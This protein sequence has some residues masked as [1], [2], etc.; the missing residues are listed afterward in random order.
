[1]SIYT[2]VVALLLICCAGL[3]CP[4]L[5]QAGDDGEPRQT[6][7]MTHMRPESHSVSCWLIQV[8]EEAFDR[9]G[10]GMRYRYIPAARA[11]QMA[12]QGLSD[13]ELGRTEF[14]G[15]SHP[16][17]VRV[18]EPHLEVNFSA[19][20]NLECIHKL[21]WESLK[22]TDYRIG[23]LRGLDKIRK[24]LS[25]FDQKRISVV[26]RDL[27]G[28]RMLKSHR[29]DVYIGPE[30]SVNHSLKSIEFFKSGV[31][32]VGILESHRAHAYLNG[33]HTELATRL[34][35]VLREMKNE[36]LLQEFA[37]QC[38]VDL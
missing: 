27:N 15:E 34:S 33:K 19:Y 24:R 2:K 32:N 25:S 37:R 8:Y 4:A 14:Y 13:G 23:Y 11:T 20:T 31:R 36:G 3:I 1:M 17:L 12:T 21:D 28:I 9:L 22:A 10:Y 18:E 5:S 38:G 35:E 16:E 29:I 6:L 26:N 30:T 7:S